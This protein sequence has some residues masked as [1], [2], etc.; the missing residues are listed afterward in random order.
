MARI[1][2][3]EF[4]GLETDARHAELMGKLAAIAER[5]QPNIEPLLDLYGGH[6]EKNQETLE[7]HFSAVN[8]AINAIAEKDAAPD[9]QPLITQIT[10][11]WAEIVSLISARPKSFRVERDA[12]GL[13]KRIVAET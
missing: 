9:L 5:P 1:P 10:E 2:N 13:I 11:A 4:E 7:K 12:K 6:F 8:Q 3:H